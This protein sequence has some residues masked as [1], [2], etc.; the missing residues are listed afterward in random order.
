MLHLPLT[1]EN[2]F[3][4][5]LDAIPEETARKAKLFFVNYPNNPTGACADLAFYEK[6]VAFCKQHNLVLVSDLAYGEI[7][8]D[9]YKPPS[10]FSVPGAKTCAI[11][12]HS[13]SKSFNMAGFRVGWACGNK[14]IVK[15]LYTIKT[16]L[17]Y[18]VSNAIQDGAAYA[19]NHA[20]EFLPAIAQTYQERRDV[21]V[22]G[23]RKL[24]WQVEPT[25]GSMYVWLPI[26]KQFETSKDWTVHLIDNADV[27][28]TPG[29]AFGDAGDD[30]RR[31]CQAIPAGWRDS[32][33]PPYHR[34]AARG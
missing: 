30:G 31:D 5:D 8:F 4:P 28:V 9:G 6:L 12:F 24:G 15:S 18:G 21:V 1:P 19:L 27:V 7:G 14:D 11:E 32:P 23:F 10:I 17:D 2:G 26:P 13:F 16:N 25:K 3:L 29:V 34:G 22:E 20:E 33:A